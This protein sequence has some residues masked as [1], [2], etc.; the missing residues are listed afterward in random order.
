MNIPF[1]AKTYY[2]ASNLQV[3]L[4]SLLCGAVSFG[5]TALMV[6]SRQTARRSVQVG[7]F[8][9][10]A[11][12]VLMPFTRSLVYFALA[13]VVACV[14]AG[15]QPLL[16]TSAVSAG[17][18]HS[19]TIPAFSSA[20][21][22]SLAV[23]PVY[24]AF[25]SHVFSASLLYSVLGLLPLLV[26]GLSLYSTLPTHVGSHPQ[27]PVGP[28]Q[29]TGL[30]GNRGYL[31]G[32]VVEIAFT[33]PFAAF[34]TYGAILAATRGAGGVYAELTLSVFF[35]ASFAARV[36]MMFLDRRIVVPLL[37][38]LTLVGLPLTAYSSS[39]LQVALGFT[40]LGLAHGLAYPLSAE[41]VAESVDR[42]SL[43]LANT[44]LSG[45]SAA[46]VFVCLPV[47]GYISQ[48]VGL[49]TVFLAPEPLVATLAV[50]FA[51]LTA[52]SKPGKH[53]AAN[54]Q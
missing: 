36:T 10:A 3:S 30:L 4:L 1:F 25:V 34:T 51:A 50:Y 32:V 19:R 53:A 35:L 22:L 20:L 14:G 44:L 26:L 8:M 18:D 37:F 52:H 17:E 43:A 15:A 33:V 47:L 27:G 48:T 6:Y 49:S 12:I 16:L 38:L 31:L 24:V 40:L 45:I 11:G 13:S 2:G 28:R 29:V 7:I 46:A 21:S 39:V 54:G 23:G 42:G 41:Y 5:G 9:M